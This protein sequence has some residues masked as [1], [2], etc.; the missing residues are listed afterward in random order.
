MRSILPLLLL[1]APPV[2]S[3]SVTLP[4]VVTGGPGSWII[5]A[6]TKVDG[7]PVKWRL[8]PKLQEVKLDAL[9]PAEYVEKLRGK[10]VTAQEAGQYKVEAWTAK[11][12][13]ASDIAATWVIVGKPS[14]PSPEPSP[15]PTPDTAPIPV[16]GFRVLIIEEEKDRIK[17]PPAQVAVLLSGRVQEYLDSKCVLGPDNK[18]REW[19]IFDKDIAARGLWLDAMKRPRQS[20]PWIII[21]D[22]KTGYEG[23]LPQNV[24]A[25][26]QL[27]KKYGG[28]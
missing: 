21:S 14:P 18:T 13:I 17:L 4:D 10:V 16:A 23:P 11:G 27:L 8:D 26:L 12:D 7:G 1:A 9:L 22:G 2:L 19:R 28:E 15:V 25:T 3:Q 20:L 6:P 5:I 24:E